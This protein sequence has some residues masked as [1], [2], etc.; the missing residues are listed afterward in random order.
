MKMLNFCIAEEAKGCIHDVKL[1]DAEKPQNLLQ[2][3]TTLQLHKLTHRQGCSGS[4]ET[5]CLEI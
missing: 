1:W 5:T 2:Q 3:W 4:K